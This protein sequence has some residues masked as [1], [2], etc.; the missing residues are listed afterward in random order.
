MFIKIK[1][2]F[3]FILTIV[4]LVACKMFIITYF[5]HFFC[6]W[7]CQMWLVAN[8][9][10]SGVFRRVIWW[11]FRTWGSAGLTDGPFAGVV[12]TGE[13]ARPTYG[14]AIVC[15]GQQREGL[16]DVIDARHIC[17]EK[18]NISRWRLDE[19]DFQLQRVLTSEGPKTN[20]HIK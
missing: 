16:A 15:H 9:M 12:V 19:F 8:R 1:M 3:L 10:V 18:L 14:R 17:V 6:T 2:S 11:S 4:S 20:L 13:A 7:R 5:F